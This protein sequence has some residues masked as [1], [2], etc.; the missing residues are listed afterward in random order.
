MTE[1][2]QTL[3]DEIQAST[4]NYIDSLINRFLNPHLQHKLRQIAMD[5][6]LKLP[7]RL[8]ATWKDRADMGLRSPAI[9]AAIAAWIGFAMNE[10][11][12]GRALQDPQADAIQTACGSATP[13]RALAALIGAPA[14]LVAAL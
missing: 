12:A 11:K 7:I 2:A 8:V 5:G 14:D 13:T 4:P 1:A 10:T 3:P 6:T 9:E